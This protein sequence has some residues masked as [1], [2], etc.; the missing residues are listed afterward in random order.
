MVGVERQHGALRWWVYA[1]R[2]VP[3]A[4]VGARRIGEFNTDI[5]DPQ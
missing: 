4:Q 3:L 2:V 5:R 1:S